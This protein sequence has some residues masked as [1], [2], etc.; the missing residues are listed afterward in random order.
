MLL[1]HHEPEYTKKD[2]RLRS[3]GALCLPGSTQPRCS[4]G[5]ETQD[6]GTRAVSR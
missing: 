1:R 3:A 6:D 5:H 4:K 2:E